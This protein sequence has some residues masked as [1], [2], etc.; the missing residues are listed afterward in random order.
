MTACQL[1]RINFG[2]TNLNGNFYQVLGD[3]S[4]TFDQGTHYQGQLNLTQVRGAHTLRAGTDFRRHERFRN[5]PGN[6]SGNFTFD[7]TYTRKADDTAESPA[8]NLGLG[9][10]AFML[11]IPTRVEAE[12]TASSLIS[13]HWLGTFFQDTWRVS[14]SVTLNFG[15]RHE[16][17]T[18][19]REKNDQMLVGFDPN[20][21]VAIAQLAEAAYARSPIPQLA[22]SAF[23]VRGGTVYAGDPGQTGLSWGGQSMWMPR[24]SGSWTINER[25][26]LKAGY[27]M[28]YDVLSATNFTPNQSGYSA[29]TANVASVDFG[30]TLAAGQPEGRRVADA[31][32]VSRAG[33]RDAL[34]RGTRQLA[35]RQHGARHAFPGPES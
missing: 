14:E 28:Y 29:T 23:D 7:N 11:G 6:A 3:N 16:Y 17:E 34:R 21:D 8:A 13:N 15:L 33:H 1:P 32:S 9:W 18:G 5:F 27:G 35:R 12:M 31:E 20:V 22:P 10:A 4:G 24:V 25:T 19:L 30:Q 26:V 2:G